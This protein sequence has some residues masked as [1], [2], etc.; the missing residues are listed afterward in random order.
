MDWL[1]EEETKR[2]QMCII[3]IQDKLG[4][5]A[6]EIRKEKPHKSYLSEKLDSIIWDVNV[7]STIVKNNEEED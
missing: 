7:L 1:N 4:S 5:I 6:S 3:N 2:A